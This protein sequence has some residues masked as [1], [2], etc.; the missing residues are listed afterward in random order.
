MTLET[1]K[2]L[3]S[4]SFLFS[5]VSIILESIASRKLAKQNQ[6]E[7][8][9]FGNVEEKIDPINWQN[10]NTIPIFQLLQAEKEVLGIYV[11]GNPLIEYRDLVA[12]IINIGRANNLHLILVE[13]IRKVYTKTRSLMLAL[14]I[15]TELGS[16]EAVIFPKNAIELSSKLKEKELYWC[17]GRTSENKKKQ[18]TEDQYSDSPKMIID[19]CDIFEI[20][21][22]NLG[23]EGI[24]EFA[25]DKLAEFNWTSLKDNPNDFEVTATEK[26]VK[27]K[28][29][30]SFGI[31]NL[32]KLLDNSSD[33]NKFGFLQV[34]IEIETHSNI[35]KQIQ[36]KIWIKETLLEQF[37]LI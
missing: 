14:E 26:I 36:K 17:K 30:R 22:L 19:S 29:S 31:L 24:S 8:L 27:I 35:W 11:S 28:I 6:S 21:I 1:T 33:N 10:Q 9:F 25:K 32:Q 15:T 37:N 34:E 5:N 18:E 13:K 16:F 20:G 4:R 12:K 3:N 7:S 2:N 23:L